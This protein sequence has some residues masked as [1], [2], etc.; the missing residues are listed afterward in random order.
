[1]GL[2]HELFPH[3]IL[4]HVTGV[5]YPRPVNRIAGIAQLKVAT[6]GGSAEVSKET[7]GFTGKVRRARS[8][9]AIRL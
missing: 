4:R 9:R 3:R 7:G 1:M 6:D 8:R 5:V 2:C